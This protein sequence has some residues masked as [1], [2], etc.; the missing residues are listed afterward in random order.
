M[1]ESKIKETQRAKIFIYSHLV[2]VLKAKPGDKKTAANIHA[3][4]YKGFAKLGGR[5]TKAYTSLY[6]CRNALKVWMASV[7]SES[8]TTLIGTM[9]DEIYKLKTRKQ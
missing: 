7:T 1:N 2:E 6:N 5:N 3:S 9:V 4:F 8:Y